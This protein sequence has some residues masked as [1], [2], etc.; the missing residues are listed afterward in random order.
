[1]PHYLEAVRVAAA[2]AGMDGMDRDE[3]I[4]RSVR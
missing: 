4:E 3:P 1:M 2:D